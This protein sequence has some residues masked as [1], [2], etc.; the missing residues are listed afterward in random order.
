MATL[1]ALG[2]GLWDPL[3]GGPAPFL[4]RVCLRGAK[5]PRSQGAMAWTLEWEGRCD[6]KMRAHFLKGVKLCFF[7]SAKGVSWLL[8]TCLLIL[9]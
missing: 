7:F 9:P 3:S 4:R 5:E 6:P 2:S 8:G 1:D